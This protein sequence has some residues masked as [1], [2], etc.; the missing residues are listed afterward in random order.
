MPH[1]AGPPLVS[2][3]GVPVTTSVQGVVAVPSLMPKRHVH[4]VSAASQVR[5]RLVM[6]HVV[7]SAI[8]D[9]VAARRPCC[10][11]VGTASAVTARREDTR[12]FLVCMVKAMMV[13]GRW[14]LSWVEG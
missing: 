9:L 2:V 7:A 13:V 6:V 10:W 1:V 5:D 11:V 3:A 12:R 4:V 14:I 8:M